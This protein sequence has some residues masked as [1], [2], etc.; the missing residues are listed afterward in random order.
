MPIGYYTGRRG[1]VGFLKSLADDAG[2]ARSAVIP[3]FTQVDST[4]APVGG[5]TGGTV[6]SVRAITPSDSTVVTTNY[7]RIGGAGN[8]AL[9]G[10]SDGA[11]VTIAVT[12][13]EYVPFSS[14]NVMATNTTATGIVAFG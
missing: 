12:A 6:A 13:G 4:G 11:A 7:L 1:F 10:T 8:L 14:G 2:V 9:K 5:V 3:A